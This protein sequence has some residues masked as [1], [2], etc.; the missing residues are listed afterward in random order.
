MN[1]RNIETFSCQHCRHY[2]ASTTRGEFCQLL[3]VPVHGDLIGCSFYVEKATNISTYSH[4]PYT[5]PIIHPMI[6]PLIPE[7]VKSD[8]YPSYQTQISHG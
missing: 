7:L 8:I 3:F 1:S 5:Y 2:R 4:A 6:N